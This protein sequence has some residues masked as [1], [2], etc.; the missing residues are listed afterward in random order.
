M[1]LCTRLKYVSRFHFCRSYKI[2]DLSNYATNND[3]YFLIAS[4]SVGVTL[5][6]DWLRAGLDMLQVAGAAALY[7]VWT[8][9]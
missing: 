2:V 3:G 6:G 1:Q 7:E 5:D 9:L 4:S 8:D